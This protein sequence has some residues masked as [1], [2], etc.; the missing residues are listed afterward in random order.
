MNDDHN[1]LEQQAQYESSSPGHNH[2]NYEDDL[3]D[4]LHLVN[5]IK[6]KM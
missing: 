4:S 3:D 2:Y 5:E 6:A 1:Y